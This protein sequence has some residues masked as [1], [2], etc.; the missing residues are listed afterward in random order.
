MQGKMFKTYLGVL[1][2]IFILFYATIAQAV[3]PSPAQIE[4]FKKLPRAQQEALARQYGVDLE[5]IMGNSS[6]T[7][8]N[9][10]EVESTIG[11]RKVLAEEELQTQEEK[12]KP[13]QEELKPFGYD[14]F[15]GEPTSFMPSESAPV[16]DDYIVRPGDQVQISLYGKESATVDVSIDR[17]G[18]LSIPKLAPVHVAGMSFKELKSLVSEK[19]SNE[20]IGVKAFVSLGQLRSIRVLVV[21]E[22]YKPGSYTLSSLSTVTHALFASGGVSD[23]ASLRNIEIKRGGKI[24]NH[25]DLYDLLIKGDSSNDIILKPGDVVFIPPVGAQV[26][27]TGAVKRPAIFELKKGESTADLLAMA[28]GLKANAYSEK[29]TVERAGN[30]DYKQILSFDFTK[31]NSGYTPQ[32]GDVVRVSETSS[33]YNNA[34]T[35]IGAVTRPGEYSWH[36]GKRIGDIIGSLRGALL[37]QADLDYA[38]LLREVDVYGNIEVYQFS[39]AKAV[40]G[41]SNHNLLLNARDKLIVFS[42]FESKAEE[43][44]ALKQLALTEEEQELQKKVK[45]WHLFEQRQFEEFVGTRKPLFSEEEEAELKSKQ[46]LTDI[47]AA[48]SKDEEEEIEY[49]TFS[50]NQLLDKVIKKLQLQAGAGERIKLV[51]V[52]GNVRFP[53]VYPLAKNMAV[54]ELITAGGG[55]TESAFLDK[56]EITRSKTGTN[57]DIEHITFNLQGALDGSLEENPLLLSKDSLNILTIPNWQ[58]NIKVK[59]EGEVTFPGQ[60]TIRRGET[61]KDVIERAGGFSDFA[62]LDAAVFTRKTIQEQERAQIE[63]LTNELRRDLAS[64]SFEYSQNSVKLSYDEMAMLISDLSQMPTLGRLV[65]NLDDILADK[66][67]LVLQDGDALYIPSKRD[68]ISVIGE[69]NYATSHLY[70]PD[71]GVDA[72]IRLSGGT[73]ARAD[74]ERIYVIKAN[75]SVYIPENKGWFAVN[76]S[77]Q[78][79]PGDTIVVPMDTAHMDSLTLWSS[80]TQIFYQLGVGIAAISGI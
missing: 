43:Q 53:G 49:A 45:L 19:V 25:F 48:R 73:K 77:H 7:N 14:I 63:R 32:D 62:A 69:V 8:T 50:R 35:L 26:S 41:D 58:E 3:N 23:I 31:T 70:N 80:A 4:Q 5:T 68:S 21:G 22:A 60:Y 54:R 57:D 55:L 9:D 36:Q 15:A 71:T 59:V 2:A 61:I 46:K 79:E 56:A 18:R 37:P 44:D 16:P 39:L 74:E 11:E 17:S 29:V 75:G 76:T 34:V 30:G 78:L 64:K 12:F 10:Q 65:I 51:E 38:I 42:R 6:K 40:A 67:Q 66:Q 52:N 1:S 72:Y 27:V 47:I 33:A 24:V 13:K 20:M 28:G